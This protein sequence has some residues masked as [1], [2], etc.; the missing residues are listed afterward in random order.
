M[1]ATNGVDQRVT[2]INEQPS[3]QKKEVRDWH[4]GLCACGN[5]CGNC[6]LTAFCYPCVVCHMY[7]MYD[8]CCGAPLILVCPEVLLT[9]KHRAKN[10]II[11]SIVNDCCTFCWCAPCATCRLYR[12]MVYVEQTKG[13]LE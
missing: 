2:V 11:G 10:R 12:D 1:A 9:V 5:N 7:R 3:S 4:D 13:L 8:E 6:V